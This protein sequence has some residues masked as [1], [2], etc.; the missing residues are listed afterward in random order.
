M[1]G[2][3]LIPFPPVLSEFKGKLFMAWIGQDRY[4]PIY[5]SS[6]TEQTK[7]DPP[8]TVPE[9]YGYFPPALSRQP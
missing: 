5:Y 1:A 2:L 4:G 9:N 7:W 8:Q 6:Y 3:I